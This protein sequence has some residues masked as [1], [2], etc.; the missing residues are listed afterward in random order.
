MKI[1]EDT[2]SIL[3]N[4][5]TVQG[6]IVINPGSDIYTIANGKNILAKATVDE[7]FP[8][9]FGIYE[10]G[11]FLS[12]VSLL[13][14]PSF[15]FKDDL[16]EVKSENSK[17]I[18]RYGYTDPSLVTIPPNGGKVEFPDPDLSFILTKE[19][20]KSIKKAAGVLNLPH[21]CIESTGDSLV[22][23][24]TDKSN[25]KVSNGFELSLW[26]EDEDVDITGLIF[27]A[28]FSVD[29]LKLF[30]GEYRVEISGQGIGHF[31]NQEIELEYW[32]S[33]ESQY[34]TIMK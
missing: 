14:D 30:P 17:Q 24:V 26:T 6:S 16:V 32:I 18:I 11:E 29:N 34:S 8:K 20:L 22:A 15:D 10:L 2:L 21:V 27:R 31:I 3:N 12:A 28:T 19:N 23:T 4:F 13:E 7:T 5:S 9:E 1:S 33:S 25:G